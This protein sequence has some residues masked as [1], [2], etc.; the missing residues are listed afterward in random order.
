MGGEKLTSTTFQGGIMRKTIVAGI[1]GAAIAAGL[2]L[3]APAQAAPAPAPCSYFNGPDKSIC[4]TPNISQSIHNARKNLQD[5]FN[6]QTALD[7]L[8]KNLSGDIE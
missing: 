8:Q 7:N 4:G 1:A 2:G 3:A 5:N 6:P